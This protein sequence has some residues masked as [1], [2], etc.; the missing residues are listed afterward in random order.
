MIDQL[1]IKNTHLSVGLVDNTICSVRVPHKGMH[2]GLCL[3]HQCVPQYHIFKIT[4]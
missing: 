3:G 4:R 2:N 1:G